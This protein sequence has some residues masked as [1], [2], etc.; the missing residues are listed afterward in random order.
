MAQFIA[1][2]PD[3]EVNG[4]TVLSIMA[5]MGESAR[6]ILAAHGFEDV[7]LDQWYSQQAWLD[8]FKEIAQL[9]TKMCDLVSI[10]MEIPQNA[11]FPPGIDSIESALMSID[12]AYHMNHRG[13]EIGNY[14]ASVVS[15]HQVDLVCRNPYPCDFDYGIIYGMSR[16]FCP[17]NMHAWVYHDN[18][19]PCRQKGADSCTYHV[20]WGV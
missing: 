2:A 8:T 12:V 9:P 20:I 10:G 15:D 17:K 3:V 11:I 5:G 19:A 18:E 7:Q 16:R 13:G 1:F 6:P 14:H 4:T